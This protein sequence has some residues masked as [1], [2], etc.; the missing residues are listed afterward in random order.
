[1]EQKRPDRGLVADDGNLA[2]GLLVSV[3]PPVEGELLAG[4]VADPRRVKLETGLD[5]LSD[6]LPVF[7]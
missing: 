6:A 1:M 3:F 5:R 2:G 7:A 4:V